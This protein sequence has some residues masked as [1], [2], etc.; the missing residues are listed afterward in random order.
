MKHLIKKLIKLLYVV[1][2][3]ILGV[4][5]AISYFMQYGTGY[6]PVSVIIVVIALL[7]ILNA[8]FFTVFMEKVIILP[9]FNIAAAPCF[10]FGIA[11]EEN[12]E[13]HLLLPFSVVEIKFN[14]PL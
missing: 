2:L 5:V 11:W 13:I 6:A 7:C 8:V 10:G 9:K 1:I 12:G 3:P 14:K 4:G